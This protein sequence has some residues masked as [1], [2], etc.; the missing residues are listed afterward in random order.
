VYR[1]Q[2]AELTDGLPSGA[3]V[4]EV[5]PG[6]GYL[7]IEMARL[8]LVHVTG[9]DISRTFV[10]IARENARQAGVRVDFRQGDAA[11]MPFDVDSFDLIV[12]Q[13]AF[14][15]FAQPVDA[16][17][18]MQ[19]V[20]RDG[21]VALIHDMRRDASGA[22]IDQEVGKMELSRLNA[23]LTKTALTMS[24]SA[25]TRGPSSSA[26]PPRARFEPATSSRKGSAW[27]CGSRHDAG[28]R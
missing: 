1:T 2:A 13:A 18:E 8:G 9:L 10:D 19:R 26:W 3:D 24:D 14:K 16:L 25:P 4:L 6:P 17:D 27:W 28:A 11:S 12:C 23:L 21:G 15:N 5:A 20:L 7:A 22:D